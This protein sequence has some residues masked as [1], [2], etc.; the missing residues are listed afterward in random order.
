MKDETP[1]PN[2]F[3]LKATGLRKSFGG[4][5][6]LHG[7]D[8]TVN[9][10]EVLALLGENGAGKSTAIKILAGDY[11]R[12]S[13]KIEI[14]GREVQINN[15]RDSSSLGIKVIYQEFSDAPDLTVAENL[16]LGSWPKK[17]SGIVDWRQMQTMAVE[18]L[19]TLGV[20]I[21]PKTIVD[22]LGVAQRQVLEIT[23][24]LAG[25]AKLLILDEPT[26]A[27]TTDETD[28][29][30]EL[31]LKL[32]EQGV[33]IIYITHRLDELERIADRILVFRDG[34]L[35]AEGEKEEFGRDE[36]VTAM[37]GHALE[38]NSEESSE[39]Q[40]FGTPVLTMK[41]AS[42]QNCFSQ[43]N[44]DVH[45]KEIVSLF[46]RIGCGALEITS[47]IFGLQKLDSGSV[48]INNRKGPPNSP[49][50]AIAN[51]QIG[52]VPVD[53]KTQGLLPIL[54]LSE[55]LSVASWPWLTKLGILSRVL[56]AKVFDKWSPVLD[57]R[58]KKGGAQ[59]VETLSGGNQQKVM[60]GR[61]LDR[62]S[63]LLVMAEPTRGVDVGA[64]AEIYRVLRDFA[65]QGM[66]V[67]VASSDI[68]EVTR[69]SDTIYVLS[70]GEVVS[71]YKA[72]EVTQAQLIREAGED[73]K[74]TSA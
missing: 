39:N 44:L 6:V 48:T 53:R 35:V 66:A 20:D 27:L 42:A 13:G 38:E 2:R 55:N 72:S 34:D 33:A 52:Y 15:P 29:L 23:R 28:A 61:W 8:I 11:S 56:V 19:Q 46:G 45:E 17:S 60:L 65:D 41:D 7:V 4:I 59:L 69:I 37:V 32:R 49:R 1:E 21:N 3:Q 68:E 31:I 5:E 58:A 74:T 12:D 40:I 26:S 18:N 30:F 73:I 57:I 25:E 24:A 9:G 54:T 67:L 71:K 64:R 16:V 70:R 14:N 43:I 50:D 63:K 22:T 36:I 62:K 47:T 51:Y 10:G